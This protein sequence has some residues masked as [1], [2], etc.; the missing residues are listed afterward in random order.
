MGKGR[1]KEDRVP[2]EKI[3]KLLALGLTKTLVAQ[4]LG[5]TQQ[6]VTNALTYEKKKRGLSPSPH[7]D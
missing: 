7:E 6:A 2:I 4:R 3:K 1:R 5:M